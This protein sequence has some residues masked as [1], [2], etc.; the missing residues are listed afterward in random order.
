MTTFVCALISAP[1]ASSSVTTGWMVLED[2]PHQGVLPAHAFPGV[3][4]RARS[5]SSVTAST[6]PLCAAVISAVSRPGLA[7]FG[8]APPRSNAS[9]HRG[10]A[11]DAGEVQRRHSVARRGADLRAGANEQLCRVDV[12]RAGGPV[13]R[14]RAVRLSGVHVRALR[15]QRSDA[16]PVRPHGRIRDASIPCTGSAQTCCRQDKTDPPAPGAILT[17][18]AFYA[19]D[20][21]S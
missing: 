14:R 18:G 12:A 16:R 13:Q 4:R 5:S 21:V 15:H 17:M 2:R 3:D 20:P 6:L 8:S 10:T 1:R 19:V 11:V 7:A 9:M